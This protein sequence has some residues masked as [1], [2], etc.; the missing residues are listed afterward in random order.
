MCY[1]LIRKEKRN[2]VISLIKGQEGMMKHISSK[3]KLSIQKILKMHLNSTGAAVLI[4]FSR[5][6]VSYQF[7][8]RSRKGNISRC[9]RSPSPQTSQ[10]NLPTSCPCSSLPATP[11]P[12]IPLGQHVMGT[13]FQLLANLAGSSVFSG[14]LTSFKFCVPVLKRI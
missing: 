10:L 7:S 3:T 9:L 12:N 11:S 13:D 6:V 8:L 2:K 14:P 4:T 1:E 5:A